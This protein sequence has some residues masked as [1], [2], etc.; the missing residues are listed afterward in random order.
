MLKLLLLRESLPQST[1]KLTKEHSAPIFIR[2]SLRTTR[3]V[4]NQRSPNAAKQSA[5]VQINLSLREI[6]SLSSLVSKFGLHHI[7]LEVQMKA[8]F[9]V[10]QK[11]SK[12]CEVF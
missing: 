8:W 4:E 3:Y 1:A 2:N 6:S 9:L 7:V 10:T 5:T 11:N 12:H